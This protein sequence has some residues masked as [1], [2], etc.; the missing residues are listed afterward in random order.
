MGHAFFGMPHFIFNFYILRHYLEYIDIQHKTGIKFKPGDTV[1]VNRKT[2]KNKVGL[3]YK[4]MGT[5]KNSNS[6]VY[7][8]LVGKELKFY[9]EQYLDPMNHG[10]IKD[11]LRM[12]KN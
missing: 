6:E 3:I 2:S 10:L 4:L 7:Q 1:Y 9:N 8:V 5:V 12:R 11:Y